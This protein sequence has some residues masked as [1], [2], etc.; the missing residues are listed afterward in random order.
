M[1]E[2]AGLCN[3]VLKFREQRQMTF[4]DGRAIMQLSVTPFKNQ[5]DDIWGVVA[6][7]INDISSGE[8]VDLLERFGNICHWQ[9]DPGSNTLFWSDG[10]FRIHSIDPHHT[11]PNLEDA[12]SFYHP[13]DRSN[14]T[15]VVE[16]CIKTGEPFQFTL[17]FSKPNDQAVIVDAADSHFQANSTQSIRVVGIFRNVTDYTRQAQLL[18]RMQVLQRDAGQEFYSYD[19]VNDVPFWSADH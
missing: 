1:S 5:T 3:D 7:V 8:A 9:L 10:V 18:T 6:T 11:V 2:L 19:L 15:E 4:N 12:I 17:K 13:E 14:V 16:N